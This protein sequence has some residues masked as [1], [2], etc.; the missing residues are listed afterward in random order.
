MS[1]HSI[2]RAI[3]ISWKELSEDFVGLMNHSESLL[4]LH[5]VGEEVFSRGLREGWKNSM[6][7]VAMS[8]FY[9]PLT[10][11]SISRICSESL[12]YAG[13]I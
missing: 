2:K 12:P 8:P 10:A 6:I 4:L 5:S 9:L 11:S 7:H 13:L 1:R 3:H